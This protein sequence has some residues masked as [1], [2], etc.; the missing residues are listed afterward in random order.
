MLRL[1]A[2][3]HS[4][5]HANRDDFRTEDLEVY[6][7]VVLL[8]SAPAFRALQNPLSIHRKMFQFPLL[9][10][11]ASFTIL[12]YSQAAICT[13]S[14]GPLPTVKDCKDIVEAV[15]YLSSLPGE[16]VRKAWGRQLPTTYHTEKLPKV[17]WISGRGPITCAINVDVDAY[18]TWAVE[19]FRVSDVASAAKGV[20]DECLVP[21]RKVGLAYPAGADGLVHA[22]VRAISTVNLGTIRIHL[23][24]QS[25]VTQ[26]V[27]LTLVMVPR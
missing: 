22:R 26:K 2:S 9:L 25:S 20:V 24:K 11:Y 13:N 27:R 5:I 1:N 8:S 23:S 21:R 17:F 16:N 7:A 19:D 3:P 18:D 14:R 6:L 10:L 4:T 12:K 15:T